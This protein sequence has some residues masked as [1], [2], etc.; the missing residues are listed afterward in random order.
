VGL[1]NPVPFPYDNSTAA[2]VPAGMPCFI[3]TATGNAGTR[4]AG[5]V[6]AIDCMNRRNF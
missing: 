5:E 4:V 1:P 3:A 2:T 6:Y